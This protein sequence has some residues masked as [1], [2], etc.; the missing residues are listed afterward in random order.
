MVTFNRRKTLLGLA[1]LGTLG[2]GR[3]VFAS[4]QTAGIIMVGASWCP[5]C[6][7]ASEQLYL[8]TL[9]WGWPVVIASTD[10]RAIEP[11]EYA[12]PSLDHPLTAQINQLP[13]TLVVAPAQDAVHAAFV[14]FEGPHKYL[15]QLGTALHAA[16]AEGQ[17]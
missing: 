2:A 13:T 16:Q 10:N 15:V 6:K 9:Q 4:T 8:A 11:F 14:G 3:S 12:I 7:M 1:A 17:M 5:F